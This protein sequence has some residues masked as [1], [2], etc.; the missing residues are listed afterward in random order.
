MLASFLFG[1]ERR[2]GTHR[3]PSFFNIN[4]ESQI[5]ALF[6][7]SQRL[8]QIEAVASPKIALFSVGAEN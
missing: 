2:A 7:V 8:N 5:K 3:T 1:K 4:F 6:A